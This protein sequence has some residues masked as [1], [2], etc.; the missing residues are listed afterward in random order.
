[1]RPRFLAA[2]AEDVSSLR[3]ARKVLRGIASRSGGRIV[4]EQGPAVVLAA[5]EPVRPI[6]PD[7]VLI[8][9]I[10]QRGASADL[11]A[12]DEG[13]ALRTAGASLMC[14]RWGG[15][16]A[17]ILHRETDCVHLVRAPLGDLAC[18]WSVGRGVLLIASDLALLLEAGFPSPAI[19]VPSLI[20]HLAAEDLRRSETCLS[21]VH[22]LRGGDRLN[23]RRGTAVRETL[24]SPWTFA[25]AGEFITD[26]DEA[27]RRVRSAVVECVGAR[28]A[29]FNRILLKLSGGL[30]S[31]IVAAALPEAQ[32]PFTALTLATEDPAGDER[33]HAALVA[34][35]LGVPLIDRYRDV[36]RVT[37]DRSAAADL[38][39]PTARSFTQESSRIATEVAT[40]GD[41]DAIFDGGGGDNVFCSLQSARPAAD[42]LMSV[43]GRGHF[44]AT[45]AAISQLAQAS[46]W[47]VARRGWA[48]SMRRSPDYVWGL[49]RRFLSNEAKAD[50][51]GEAPH[52]WLVAP[53]GALPGTAAHVALIAAAQSVTEGFDPRE[54]LPTCSPLISQPIVEACLQIPTWLWFEN[55]RNRS[56]A[57]RAFRPLLP[58]ATVQRRSKGA[59]DCF[60]ADLY[61]ANR[62]LIRQMLMDGVLRQL[63]LLDVAAVEKELD[64]DPPVRGQHFL[65]IM[66]LTDTEAWARCWS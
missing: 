63:G 55:G 42:C 32:R 13:A 47:M 52:P 29:E 10:F 61:D 41:C 39:R 15:Y 51:T 5:G 59:P 1:M 50:L 64:E 40:A 8:G 33:S 19:D 6:G 3:N 23:I 7:G 44:W 49:D 9:P 62:G 37:L 25:A 20:R 16:V 18:Y 24:W 56:V 46:I 14:S 12:D 28:A 31:S 57:R 17:L 22:E 21:G 48:I 34:K 60:I 65:R 4:L 53:R 66:Q 2:V 58:S 26:P 36:S 27:S 43:R 38:P 54:G 35:A 45:C 30:D 11:S